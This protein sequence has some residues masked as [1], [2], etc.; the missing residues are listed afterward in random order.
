MPAASGDVDEAEAGRSAAADERQKQNKE[1]IALLQRKLS[2]MEEMME[3]L[4][5]KPTR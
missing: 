3:R 4:P 1:E 2:R 5:P